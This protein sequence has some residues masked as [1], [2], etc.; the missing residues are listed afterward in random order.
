MIE[1]NKLGLYTNRAEDDKEEWE[2][3][4][5]EHE[6]KEDKI[7]K[8]EIFSMVCESGLESNFQFWFQTQF[9]LPVLVINI[10]A[11][12]NGQL[13]ITDLFNWRIFSIVLSFISISWTAVK[14]RHVSQAHF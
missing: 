1:W 12:T 9:I 2:K 7:E 8:S 10:L 4:I 11:Y 6:E 5:R 14:I 13:G 3:K